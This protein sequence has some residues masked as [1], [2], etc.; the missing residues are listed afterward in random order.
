[1]RNMKK[2]IEKIKVK[3]KNETVSLSLRK[4]EKINVELYKTQYS[5]T[6]DR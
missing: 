5:I 3:I 1:M 6:Y 4:H 2:D